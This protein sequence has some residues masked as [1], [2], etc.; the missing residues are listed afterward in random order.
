MACDLTT[1]ISVGCKDSSGGIKE[2]YI[3][4]K[5]ATAAVTQNASGMVTALTIGGSWYKYVPRT[6]VGN[7]T[8]NPKA[9]RENGTLYFEQTANMAFNKMEQSKRNEV[10][11]LGKA[12]VWIIVKDQNDKYWLLGQDNGMEMSDSEAGSGTA[13]ADRNGYSL[14]FMGMEPEAAPEV[15]YSAF[16][17]DISATT[18]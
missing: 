9:N 12:N 5:D 15:L 17:G 14:V 8:D 1:G 13:L 11:L 3:A 7:F 2:F 10:I 6:G 16:S 18:I 4:N